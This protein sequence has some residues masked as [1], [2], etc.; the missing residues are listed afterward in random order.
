MDMA[1]SLKLKVEIS[2]LL[3][4]PKH[5]LLTLG[6][7]FLLQKKPFPQVSYFTNG[8]PSNATDIGG[9]SR[10]FVTRLFEELFCPRENNKYFLPTAPSTEGNIWPTVANGSYLDISYKTIGRLFA[11]CYAGT[12]SFKTGS[13]FHQ[14]LFRILK[15]Q[16]IDSYS[17]EALLKA[18]CLLKNLPTLAD[19]LLGTIEELATETLEK[20]PY[21][22]ENEIAMPNGPNAYFSTSENKEHYKQVL[23]E[24]AKKEGR[25]K[26]AH[27]IA[28]GMKA[29]MTQPNWREFCSLSTTEIQNTIQGELSSSLIKQRLQWAP[30]PT[31]S[32]GN[33][34]RVKEL[35]ENWI[36]RADKKHLSLFVKAI[37]SNTTLGKNPL[38]M[39]VYNR[40]TNFIPTAHTCYFSLELSAEYE[41]QEVFDQKINILLTE[42]L[43]KSGFQIS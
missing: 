30:S 1:L 27:F 8:A 2:S 18:F 40:G 22:L 37:T 36:D 7:H 4:N 29:A 28:L 15:I 6:N 9:V 12:S 42:G 24:E 10:D 39:E 43:A 5:Y 34:N 31:V 25:L 17:E 38:K 13:I 35:L 16:G 33:T 20:T 26:A 41:S 32:R 14:D 21:L 11:L 19:F 3:K 23:V